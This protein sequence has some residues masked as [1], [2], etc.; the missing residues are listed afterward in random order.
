[1]LS[2]H[3]EVPA[4]AVM[5]AMELVK[6]LGSDENAMPGDELLSLI[7]DAGV[8]P[9]ELTQGFAL[10]IGSFMHM[11]VGPLDLVPSLI[12]KLRALELVPDE[13]LP[14]MPGALTAAALGQSPLGCRHAVGSGPSIAGPSEGPLG[15]IPHGCLPTF[16]I[17]RRMSRAQR[18][19]SLTASSPGCW[20]TM[21]TMGAE[22]DQ[23]GSRSVRSRVDARLPGQ[24]LATTRPLGLTWRSSA[25]MARPLM[26]T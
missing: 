1:M 22:A 16:S 15:R 11:L 8:S 24:A 26:P 21:L 9:E 17:S 10:L 2:D 25:V 14:T 13:V 4:G 20:G 18:L 3:D 5:A 7:R 19:S 23:P 6:G 12:R